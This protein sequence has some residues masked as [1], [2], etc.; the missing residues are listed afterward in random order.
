MSLPS[1]FAYGS[2]D[3]GTPTVTAVLP[4][5][6]TNEGKRAREALARWNEEVRPDAGQKLNPDIATRLALVHEFDW[7]GAEREYRRAIELNPGLA[8]AHHWYALLLIEMNR[9][10][11][12]IAE[13]QRAAPF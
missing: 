11:E 7:A 9:P 8:R 5:S 1:C 12:A 4:A 10:N 3:A 13:I 2:V 6:G